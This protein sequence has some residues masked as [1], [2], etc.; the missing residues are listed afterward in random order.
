MP[1][2]RVELSIE[3]DEI[4]GPFSSVN[5]VFAVGYDQ[6]LKLNKSGSI[7]WA[8]HGKMYYYSYQE[9]GPQHNVNTPWYYKLANPLDECSA[10]YGRVRIFMYDS[11]IVTIDSFSREV[12]L[13]RNL[14]DAFENA[15]NI[16]HYFPD[17]R[18]IPDVELG[19]TAVLPK[20]LPT[21]ADAVDVMPQTQVRVY[22]DHGKARVATDKNV[23]I[24]MADAISIIMGDAPST[25]FIARLCDQFPQALLSAY[26]APLIAYD[27]ETTALSVAQSIQSLASIQDIDPPEAMRTYFET[28]K[29]GRYSIVG[30][31]GYNLLK[32]HGKDLQSAALVDIALA[33]S[34]SPEITRAIM[35]SLID[36]A[37]AFLPS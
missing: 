4:Y 16:V 13:S 18:M 27:K 19:Y 11:R 21:Q 23:L 2:S 34:S 10:Q 7:F 25:Q 8:D 35:S 6:L 3:T 22:D 17:E 37:H 26:G 1:Y 33:H 9:I 29:V 15:V 5:A 36:Q 32:E 28:G 30:G 31:W 12:Y 14:Q 24:S 20:M